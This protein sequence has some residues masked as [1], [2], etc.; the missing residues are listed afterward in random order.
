MISQRSYGVQPQIAIST[1]RFAVLHEDQTVTTPRPKTR[2]ARKNYQKRKNKYLRRKTAASRPKCNVGSFTNSLETTKESSMKVRSSFQQS[3]TGVS[4]MKKVASGG[5]GPLKT[6]A[7]FGGP[8]WL[9]ATSGGGGPVKTKATFGGPKWLKATSG[10]GG[11]VKTKATSG[12]GPPK[13][14]K[15]TSGGGPPKWLKA[16]SCGGPVMTNATTAQ[17]LLKAASAPK[18]PK[19]AAAPKLPKAASTPKLPKAAAGD[20]EATSGIAAATQAASSVPEVTQAAP[21]D[22]KMPLTS[23]GPVLSQAASHC[24]TAD[25]SPPAP[26]TSMLHRNAMPVLGYCVGCP[27]LLCQL[28]ENTFLQ[29]DWRCRFQIFVY[30]CTQVCFH[31]ADACEHM[32]TC[33]FRENRDQL[34]RRMDYFI[35]CCHSIRNPQTQTL[36]YPVAQLL[37]LLLQNRYRR[38]ASPFLSALIGRTLA[39]MDHLFH[40]VWDEKASGMSR[41]D[42]ITRPYA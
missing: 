30:G 8:K 14:L 22:T 11:P 17:N 19:A 21:T 12:G 29:P 18:L 2:S 33:P 4:A 15:A 16:T 34:L 39:L 26:V 28:H 20:P 10:G 27:H 13:W 36:L 5:G 41:Q 25:S 32:P 31:A 23:R 6:K 37:T 24:L 7:A 9:K 42:A 3:A 38:E 1:S 35:D 40:P